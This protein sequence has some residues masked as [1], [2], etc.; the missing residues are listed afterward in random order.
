M[1]VLLRARLCFVF[2]C[3]C[4]SQKYF[5]LILTDAN[6]HA[7]GYEFQSVH[8]GCDAVTVDPFAVGSAG[9]VEVK[10]VLTVRH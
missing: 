10:I 5:F 8:I 9:H 4:T 2:S 1:K 7:I 3:V 6:W